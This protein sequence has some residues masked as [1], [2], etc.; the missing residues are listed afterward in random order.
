MFGLAFP[1]VKYA[2]AV[3]GEKPGPHYE[4]NRLAAP[5]TGGRLKLAIDG[6]P[7]GPVEPYTFNSTSDVDL[8]APV[9]EYLIRVNSQLL[10]TPELALSWTP[11][12][13]ASRWTVKL[14]PNVKFQTGQ[15]MTADDVVATYNLLTDPSKGSAALAD[16]KGILSP[17]GVM[18]GPD[19]D[20]V[21]FDLEVPTAFF[22]YLISSTAYQT[23]V[24]P[25]S[26][27]IG[28]FTTT[29]QGTGPFIMTSYTT[30]VSATY[31]RNNSWWG[32]TPP[33]EGIDSTVYE[34]NAALDAALLSG[35]ADLADYAGDSTLFGK[36]QLQIYKINAAGEQQVAMRVDT[37]P[38]TD[39]RVRQ[40]LAYTIDRP[41]LLS[42][43]DFG[44]GN[45]GNDH[46]F[47]PAYPYTATLP[48][49][50]QDLRLAKE[51]LT[52]AG[53]PDGFSATLTTGNEPTKA[54]IAEIVQASAKKVGINI[55]LDLPTPT[56]YY[57]GSSSTTPWLNAPFTVT[58]WAS[59]PTVTPYLTGTLMTGGTWNAA[60]YSN[61]KFDSLAKAF[62]G[63]IALADQK[64]YAAQLE[65][66]LLH[67]TPNLIL[68]WPAQTDAGS[69]KVRGFSP[70]PF[71][72]SLGHVSMAS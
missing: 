8:A 64:K 42:S 60:R 29:P 55:T 5:T 11:N 1:A 13:D 4:I 59:R 22:P 3:A 51:L 57:G 69:P 19:Q 31:D 20:T 58:T 45:V 52:A 33:L 63:S 36:P 46:C 28:T 15:P 10:A 66:I 18:A 9:G 24:L 43:V 67:D 47:A 40:A 30:S 62:L 23:M 25:A 61:P 37:K 65:A 54:T 44:L 27:K 49:R 50:A 72:L 26:Y 34:T 35:A 21:V 41:T 6:A 14:R 12:A 53:Y 48:Q 68:A 70:E 17:S 38:W 39:Y 2:L 56:V 7:Y 71:G 32:G 16:F